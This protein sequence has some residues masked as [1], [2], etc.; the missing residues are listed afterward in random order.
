MR[1]SVVVLMAVLFTFGLPIPALCIAAF[2]IA[3][4]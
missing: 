1:F 3:R 4:A 2:L